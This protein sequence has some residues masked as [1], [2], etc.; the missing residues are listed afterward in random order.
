MMIWEI[1]KY[2]LLTKNQ[3][4]KSILWFF[5]YFNEKYWEILE[6][7]WVNYRNFIRDYDLKATQEENRKKVKKILQI[8]E[9]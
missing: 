7:Q 1:I 8:I 5:K 3:E 2:K 9:K 6:A 4:N